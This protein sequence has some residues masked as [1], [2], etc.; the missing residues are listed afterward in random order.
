MMTSYETYDYWRSFDDEPEPELEPWEC[1]PEWLDD[2][3]E[4]GNR[5]DGAVLT[6]QEYEDYVRDMEEIWAEREAENSWFE[7]LC[8]SSFQDLERVATV[9]H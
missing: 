2:L 4:V 6:R 7:S 8:N 5:I 1:Q 3:A 9:R